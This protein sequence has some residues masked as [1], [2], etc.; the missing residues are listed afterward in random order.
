MIVVK[1]AFPSLNTIEG[2]TMVVH[3]IA[4]GA[5]LATNFLGAS[6]RASLVRYDAAGK[7]VFTGD[8]YH[9]PAQLT[10]VNYMPATHAISLDQYSL[11]AGDYAHDLVLSPDRTRIAY[12][13]EGGI[14]DVLE[15]SPQNLAQSGRWSSGP[16]PRAA[17]FRSDSAKLLIGSEVNLTYRNGIQLFDAATHQLERSWLLQHCEAAQAKMRRVRLS[18]SGSYAFALETCGS[19]EG[20][21]ARLFWVPTG[22]ASTM[23]QPNPVAFVSKTAAPLNTDIVSNEILITGLA[24][25][26]LPISVTGGTYQLGGPPFTAFN[27]FVRDGDRVRVKQTSWFASGVTTTTTLNIGGDLLAFNVTTGTA[28]T[29]T[30]PDPFRLYTLKARP[31]DT[32]FTSNTISVTGT[33]AP[34]AISASGGR[35]RVNGGA[36]TAASGTV[37]NG[38]IVT[39]KMTSANS[40][41]TTSAAILTIGN[42]STNMA[43]T[44][45][46]VDMTPDNFA[47]A[48]RFRIPRGTWIESASVTITGLGGS[49][50]VSITGGEYRIGAGPFSSASGAVNSGQAVTVR[51]MSDA[52]PGASTSATLSI[53]P[54]SAPFTVT[55]G[56]ARADFAADGRSDIL[57]R[58]AS[59]GENYLYPTN[60][61]TIMA[62]EGYL[63]TVADLN[64]TIAGIGDFDGDGR[65]DILWRNTSTGQNYVYLMNGT[66]ILT[67][68]YLRTVADLNWTI[69]GV[70]DFDGDGK[71]DILWRNSAT[72][73]NYIYLMNGMAIRTESYLRQ[74]VDLNWKIVGVGDFDGDGAADILWRNAATGENYLYPMHGRTIKPT[75]GYLRTVADLAWQIVAVGDYDGDGKSDLLWRNSS[76][77]Q[78]YVYPMDGTTIKPAEGYIRTVPV[79]NW[80]VVSR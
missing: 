58:N 76:T 48:P 41:N 8:S 32:E 38:D 17:D 53:G 31:L 24:G 72:G 18:P 36:Y 77:G 42:F 13:V 75:E 61:T 14:P 56:A 69:A 63:R 29:D 25:L 16:F 57:W 27:A 74:V 55:T 47:F 30:A 65:A 46:S 19:F 39:L 50:A 78:N 40:T 15:L 35:Y 7:H 66:A 1:Q 51:V 62:G 28:G 26:S 79:A 54:R 37:V 73:E 43:V 49:A 67:E 10:R 22:A 68:G 71:A 60:G 3:D 2:D 11:D 45:G 23:P 70:G 59:T 12:P 64:W 33:E 34:A 6:V 4:S 9:S 20:D 21:S 44:T 5:L 80:S 52:S